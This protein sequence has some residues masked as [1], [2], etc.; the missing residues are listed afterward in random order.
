MTDEVILNKILDEIFALTSPKID[1]SRRPQIKDF[2]DSAINS[3]T[4]SEHLVISCFLGK[5]KDGADRDGALV[6]LLTDTRLIKIEI[7]QNS[8]LSSSP[9]LT[10]IIKI[11]KKLEDND[12]AQVS[13]EFQNDYF[14]LRYSATNTEI[15]QFF[16]KVDAK[17]TSR[18]KI[19]GRFCSLRR[20]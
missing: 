13:I 20:L 12:A 18:P 17:R 11:D 19:M 16:Q 6:Y 8:I 10:S 7:D 3:D 14:G 2:I 4:V 9:T 1:D 5:D 15:T